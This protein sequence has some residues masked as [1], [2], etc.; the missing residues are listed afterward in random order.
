MALSETTIPH[1]PRFGR[2][3]LERIYG[4]ELFDEIS[5]DLQEIYIDQVEK[6]GRW[7]ASANYMVD[8]VL[9]LRNYDLKYRKRSYKTHNNSLA[10]FQN[11]L[12]MTFRNISRN[13]VYSALNIMGL[14][15]GLAACLFIFQYV[16]Y[17]QSYD[18]FH[19]NHENLY[20]IRYMVYRNGEL[21]IDCAAA[22]PRVGPFM[23]ENMPEV[24][25]FARAFPTSGIVEYENRVF[26]EERMHFADPAF[27]KMFTYPMIAGNPETA[28]TEPN[29]VVVTESTARKYFGDSDWLGKKIR[30]DQEHTAEITGVVEDVPNNSHFKFDFLISYE[31]LNNLTRNDDG[32]SASETAWGWYD[33]NSYVLL[34]PGVDIDDYNK[35]F[36]DVLFAERGEDFE[37]YNFK[38]EFPL[39]PIVDIHLYS[40]LLQESEPEEQGDGDAVFFLSVI[41]IF[42]LVIAWINYI[43]LSTARAIERAKE[44]GIRKTMGAFRKQL[45]YQFLAES[46]V[47]NTLA[48]VL[49]LLIVIGGI[50]YFNMLTDS[51][52]SLGFLVD[53]VF[54]LIVVGVLFVGSA[55]S[56]LYPAF[57]LSSFQPA[58][59]L[60]GRMSGDRVGNQLRRGLVVLQFTFSVV[61]IAGTVVVYQQLSYMQ[62]VDLGFEMV[63]RLVIHGP[64]AYAGSDSSYVAA[65]KSFK[66]EVA[67]HSDVADISNSSNVPGHEIFW[68]TGIKKAEE[69]DDNFKTIY[70]AGV[71][72]EYFDTYGIEL[73]AGRNYG[74]TFSDTTSVILNLSG[75]RFVGFESAEQAIGKKVT[76]RGREQTIV[77]VVE[78]Y[79]QM[80]LK[81]V[82]APIVFPLV[83]N[84]SRFF[85]VKLEA[86]RYQDVLQI[87]EEQYMS[88]FP[89]NPFEYFFLD[90]YYNRQYENDRTFSRVFLLFAAFAIIVAC[91]GLFG[92]SSFSALK[93]TKEI[94]IR[95]A[96]GADVGQIV[97]LLSKE[98][99]IL[100]VIGNVLAWPLI[101]FGMGSWLQNFPDRITIGVPVFL[102]SALIVVV[103]AIITVSYKTITA[104]RSN[105]VRALR[106]E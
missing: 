91:L 56:G 44:V 79:N 10:M 48:M 23:K 90:Q 3:L 39:Q 74:P 103:I 1:P 78:D 97:T 47:L 85:T 60:K 27:L 4:R 87:A 66:N 35:R 14:A 57:V 25:E 37:K 13:K 94:G 17:E 105:P 92:L 71:D 98:F 61:C 18:K 68:T 6:K 26:R 70:H 38:A 96:I 31:T 106:Y 104:A 41:A 34:E 88:R 86:G 15:L 84:S 29:S 28:L 93:R 51:V 72:Y 20:R 63:D 50:R 40:N 33:F 62:S 2:W 32:T 52:L 9:S 36:A 76:N 81:N 58:T 5:G 30:V 67:R 89:G 99:L 80:S 77:G 46:L 8:A 69:T 19:V 49:A 53:P 43:N 24:R 16:S 102:I 21:N 75:V 55:L 95:K 83:E 100:V 22:V 82:I 45:V 11:Y 12:K 7:R 73:L 64:D 42:I 54:W 101:Y 59:V 65:L